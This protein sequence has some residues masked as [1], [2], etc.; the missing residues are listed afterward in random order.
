[1]VISG[2][3]TEEEV[4]DRFK[5]T[6]EIRCTVGDE[7]YLYE[8]NTEKNGVV[9]LPIAQVMV[10]AQT[11]VILWSSVNGWS[12]IVRVKKPKGPINYKYCVDLAIDF[13]FWS[14]GCF[15]LNFHNGFTFEVEFLCFGL[16]IGRIVDEKSQI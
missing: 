10:E 1:M 7:R 16:Y 15:N 13:K 14:T 4:L 3:P 12:E 8:I 5:D 2:I 9:Y 6:R 11:G